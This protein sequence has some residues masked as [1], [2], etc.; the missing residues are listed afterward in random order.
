M[1]KK[2][3]IA[4]LVAGALGSVTAHAQQPPASPHTVTGNIGLFS[5]Y[6]FRGL[7]QTDREPALQGGMDY[8]H[9]SG[10]Y[11][12]TWGSNISWLRDFGSYSAGGSLELDIYG[13]FKGTIGKS[14]FGYDAGLLYYWYPGEPAPG[15]AD[16][17]TLEVYG[18]L[19]W[20][21]LSAKLSY[22]L[23]DETFGVRDSRGTYYLDL[24][25]TFPI[26]NTKLT[27]IGHYGMQEFDG[28]STACA[29]GKN[30]DC[31]SYKD[32]KIG[33]NYA[34]P[35]DVTIGAFYTDTNTDKA[36]RSTFYTTP[37]AAG[38]RNVGKGTA[39]IFVQKTF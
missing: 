3:I 2:T 37:A 13:G 27:V 24:T 1:F 23:L 21:W 39:T 6:I 20:K 35:K 29:S 10:F 16:A 26:P 22:S 12:G 9:S 17:D 28:N 31:A 32:W 11:V 38:A 34:L 14:D 8:S 4:G 7:T 30:D 5:Q 33:V 15:V 19:S 36:P 18:A 25:A